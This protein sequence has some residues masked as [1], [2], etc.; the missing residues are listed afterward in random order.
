MLDE[1]H[2]ELEVVADLLDERLRARPP[3]RGSARRRARRG[4]AAAASRRARARARRASGSRTAARR[5][6]RA[7]ARGDRRRRAP[8]APRPRRACRPCPCAPT[9][10]FS[11]TDIVRKSWM[12]WNVRATP[13]RTILNAGCLRS[14]A[15]SRSTVARVGRVQ[16]RDDVERRRLA[17]A[18]RP[19]QARDLAFL[20][21]E[22][23]AVEGDDAAEAQGD[24][25]YL[26]E[27][28][29]SDNPKSLRRSESVARIP[30]ARADA[31]SEP[32]SRRPCRARRARSR[33]LADEQLVPVRAVARRPDPHARTRRRRDRDREEPV[34]VGPARAADPAR[35]LVLLEPDAERLPPERGRTCPQ[36]S[37]EP[38]CRDVCEHGQPERGVRGLRRPR[39][40]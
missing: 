13:L 36:R 12:F 1:E 23:H 16:A 4:G 11:R 32:I 26:E 9:S 20:D 28:H 15:P 29:R 22:R 2:G 10:T 30:I 6:G 39:P 5:P 34:L 33:D 40:P 8:R 25:P 18:V 27:G 7:H 31:R 19:D 37:T 38:P 35:P 3:P 21:V 17:G 24:V 14:D